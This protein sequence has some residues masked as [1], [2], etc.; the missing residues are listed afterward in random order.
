VTDYLIGEVF[1]GRPEPIQDFLLRTCFLHRLTG[2]LCDAIT[3]AGD[4]ELVLGQL[5]RENLFFV[6]LEPR[7]GRTWYRYHPLFAESI[8]SLARQRLGTAG[9]R[10]VF[11]K[12]SAWYAEQQLFDDAI[13]TALMA[14][15]FLRALQCW[16]LSSK[17]IA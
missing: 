14:E 7:R 16:K 12:A 15:L 2:D 6:Q 10:S 11:E 4:G 8:Q 1:E 5:E 9:L 3:G 13:E 17:F